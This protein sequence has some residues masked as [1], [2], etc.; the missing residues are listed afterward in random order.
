M[1][2]PQLSLGEVGGRKILGLILFYASSSGI[3]LLVDLIKFIWDRQR[4]NQYPN[5]Q[6]NGGGHSIG[7]LPMR[8]HKNQRSMGGGT[9]A[10]S[11]YK[12]ALAQKVSDEAN[13]E[14]ITPK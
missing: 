3:S 9:I 2:W 8:A 13:H 6:N 4:S 5:L 1:A 14:L 7:N 11:L 10:K 12:P